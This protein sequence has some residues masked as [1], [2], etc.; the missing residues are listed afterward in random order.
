MCIRKEL[1]L[2]LLLSEGVVLA[3]VRTSYVYDAEWYYS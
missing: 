1:C 3:G 2:S